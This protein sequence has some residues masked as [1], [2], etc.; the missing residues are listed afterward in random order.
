MNRN[1]AE[2]LKI[3]RESFSLRRKEKKRGKKKVGGKE[4]EREV[5]GGPRECV[6]DLILNISLKFFAR[7]I[8]LKKTVFQ[9]DPI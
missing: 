3:R 6:V 2:M 4:R 9:K 1:D 8:S 7:I 5:D